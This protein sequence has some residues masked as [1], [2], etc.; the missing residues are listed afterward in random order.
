MRM[1][2]A[3]ST[4]PAR[5]AA[6]SASRSSSSALAV[7]SCTFSTLRIW[8]GIFFSMLWHWSSM[9]A[10]SLPFPEPPQLHHDELD[11]RARRVVAGVEAHDGAL[12]ERGHLRVGG[13]PVRHV[14]V[15]EGRLEDLVLEHEPLALTDG[16]VDLL[17]RLG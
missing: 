6:S 1:P 2:C 3:P 15:V 5:C 4:S 14:R 16:A 12:A 17:Q 8:P 7:I 13:A 10:T 9:N 11:V